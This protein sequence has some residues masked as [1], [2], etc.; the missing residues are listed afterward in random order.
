MPKGNDKPV[1]LS[2]RAALILRRLEGVRGLDQAEKSV[3]ALG[4][5]ATAQERWDLLR[6]Q[7]RLLGF[8]KPSI[9]KKSTPVLPLERIRE[10]KLAIGRD[11]DELHIRLIDEFLR[12]QRSLARRPHKKK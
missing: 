6:R 3:H 10:S 4:L 5:A 8:W 1:S 9:Q 12:C 7:N 2:A 11:K